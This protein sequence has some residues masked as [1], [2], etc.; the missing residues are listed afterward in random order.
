VVL[1]AIS[2]SGSFRGPGG[3]FNAATAAPSQALRAQVGLLPELA[4][5]GLV[6]AGKDI[7]MAGVCGT[8]LMMLESSGVGARIDLDRI[9]AP[10]GVDPLRW[11][12]AFPSFG[13]VLAVEPEHAPA[14][15]ARFDA[16]GVVCAVIGE[17]DASCTLTLASDGVRHVYW[18]L[19][20]AALTG[21]GPTA[22]APAAL[23]LPEEMCRA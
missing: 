18:D 13:F 16:L 6:A 11:L 23:P 1:G 17:I 8:T 4:D 10:A 5:A 21:F 14:V 22:C 9:P 7:S 19:R 12:T 15:C 20:E 3:N 2:L